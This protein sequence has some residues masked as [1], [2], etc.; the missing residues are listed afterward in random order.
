[1]IDLTIAPK[2]KAK[3]PG[4]AVGWLTATLAEAMEALERGLAK[5]LRE[6]G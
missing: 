2:F 5:W 6:N 4:V 3:I 1:M